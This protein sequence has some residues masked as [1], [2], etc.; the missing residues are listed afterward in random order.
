MKI[1]HAIPSLRLS[2]GGPSRSVTALAQAQAQSGDELFIARIKGI[3]GEVESPKGV[4]Y[5]TIAKGNFLDDSGNSYALR[6]FDLIHSHSLWL[7]F[8][9]KVNCLAYKNDIPLVISPRGTLEP[10]AINHKRWKK[11]LAWWLYQKKDLQRSQLLHATSV[12]EASGFKR[13]GLKTKVIVSPNGIFCNEKAPRRSSSLKNKKAL[14][15]GRFHPIKNIPTLLRAWAELNQQDWTLQLTGPDEDGH[16][17]TL[18]ALVESL[19]IQDRVN[20]TDS[21][22]GVE[23]DELLQSSAFL[24]LPSHTENFGMVVLEALAS[25]VPVLA[26]RGTPWKDLDVHHC[27]WWV[28]SGQ[29]GLLSAL[30]Q[31]V[32]TQADELFYMGERG[33]RLIKEKYQWP[34]IAKALHASYMGILS[35]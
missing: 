25:G 33:M 13:M 27:G 21:L 10:W 2:A 22:C 29:E 30:R 4:T 34:S 12:A 5:G 6:A 32:N 20:F 1:L 19:G 9:H 24:I 3:E 18:E 28:D 26:S 35:K 11:Q 7:S 14:Y 23:K 16:R 17:A 8:C 31:A 15:L